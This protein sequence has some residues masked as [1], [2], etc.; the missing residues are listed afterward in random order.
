MQI[1]TRCVCAKSIVS[2]MFFS[3][4]FAPKIVCAVESLVPLVSNQDS[5]TECQKKV[6][7]QQDEA[8]LNGQEI[9]VAPAQDNDDSGCDGDCANCSGC[10]NDW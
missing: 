5:V 3:L 4:C 7:D 10:D 2:V 1:K 9:V 8:I 6:S